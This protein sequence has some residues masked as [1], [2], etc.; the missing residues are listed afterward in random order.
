M[1]SVSQKNNEINS[2]LYERNL[3]STEGLRPQYDPRPVPTKYVT[4]ASID[5]PNPI[6]QGLVPPFNV[7]KGF[8][9][10]SRAPWSGFASN[11]GDDRKKYTVDS[12]SDMYRHQLPHTDNLVQ[13]FPNLFKDE[14]LT[15][16]RTCSLDVG[17]DLFNNSTR[18]QLRGINK[19]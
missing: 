1:Q 4:M 7:N 14:Q 6:H 13:P 9:P 3:P 12:N 18:T 17:K 8:V 16:S 19:K 10:G 5:P 11:I 15:S 2:R